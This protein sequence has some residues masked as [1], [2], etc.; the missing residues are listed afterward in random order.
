MRLSTPRDVIRWLLGRFPL[1]IGA[2]GRGSSIARPRD[3][4]GAPHV[5]MGQR[6]FI[7]PHSY[8]ECLSRWGDQ[9]FS[10][11][12]TIGDGVYI[13]GHLYLVCI[14]RVR[15]GHRCVLSEHVYISDNSHGFD[16]DA[17]P[18]MR[19]PLESKGPIEIGDDCFIGYRAVV[20]PGVTLGHH[21]VV[22]ANAVVTKSF[23]PYSMVAGV[24]ARLIRRYSPEKRQWLP[25]D[26]SQA[27]PTA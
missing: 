9:V 20:M 27:S 4:R 11:T 12:V 26:P 22:G 17:G 21:C 16:P 15:I 14:A 13:G 6:S 19:Q 23:P 7:R 5:T 24:P 1:A 10:P 3:I 2:C 25:V 8:I 18:I